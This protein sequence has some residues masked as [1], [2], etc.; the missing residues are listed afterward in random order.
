M[1]RILGC[2]LIVVFLG[3]T[4]L[5]SKSLAGGEYDSGKTL[6]KNKCQLCHG[7]RGDGRGPAAESLTRHP[8]DFTDSGFWQK[9]VEKKIEDTIKKGKE[10]M[11]AFD[12]EIDEINAIIGYMSH[13]FKKATQNNEGRD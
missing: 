7:L 2:A 11:P 10:M 8:V 9:D 5:L 6:Y 13:T 3:A 4:P 1:N 12:L